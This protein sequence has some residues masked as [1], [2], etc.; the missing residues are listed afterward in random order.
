MIKI[1]VLWHKNVILKN[2]WM[3][4]TCEYTYVS[5]RITVTKNSVMFDN[6]N[7]YIQYSL[8]C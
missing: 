2:V 4:T 5:V 6:S 8:V 1:L 3:W 7:I